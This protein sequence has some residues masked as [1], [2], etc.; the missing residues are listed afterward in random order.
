MERPDT[1]RTALLRRMSRRIARLDPLLTVLS[2]LGVVSVI[3]YGFELG[4]DTA[5]AVLF[6][7]V[8]TALHL[9]FAVT[10][11][12]AADPSGAPGPPGAARPANVARGTRRLWRLSALGGGAFVVGDLTQLLA[13]IRDPAASASIAGTDTQALFV[14]VGLITVLIGMLTCPLGITSAGELSRL[15]LDLATVMAAATT[16]GMYAFVLPPGEPSARWAL[17]LVIA[18]LIEPG[19]SMIAVF[20]VIKLLLSPHP[21]ATR[22]A[23]LLTGIAAGLGVLLQVVPGAQYSFAEYGSQLLGGNIVAAGLL[24]AGARVQQLQARTDP[25][26]RSSRPARPYSVLPYAAI[27]AT[28]LLL[29]VALAMDGLDGHAWVVLVGAIASTALVVARQLAAFRHIAELLGERD[30][31]AAQ[32]TEMAFH[33]GLTGLA[34]RALFMQRL[35]E[36]LGAGDGT[37]PTAGGELAVVLIDLDDFKPINDRY[38]HAAGDELLRRVGRW[39]TEAVRERDTVARIGGDEFAVL[40]TDVPAGQRDLS[41]RMTAVLHRHTLIGAVAVHARASVGVAFARPGMR[42]PDEL[43]HEADLDMYVTKRRNKDRAE[44]SA[45]DARRPGGAGSMLGEAGATRTQ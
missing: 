22:T 1:A 16:L 15:R 28:Y 6:W 43:L 20:A 27:G 18:L 24:A 33:D 29:V 12:R 7:L 10:A 30:A 21:P 37:P 19:L 8:L 41:Q 42:T 35:T 31:L 32:L 25:R 14:I 26:M 13:V 9:T 39:L 2:L 38:G 45:A 44:V 5:R 3:G 40:V 36:A 23:A 17:D 4:P 11:W 34:N